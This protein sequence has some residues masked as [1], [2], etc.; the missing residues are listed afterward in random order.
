MLSE[1]FVNV[2]VCQEKSRLISIVSIARVLGE[3]TGAGLGGTGEG[4][5]E[6]SEGRKVPFTTTMHGA[7]AAR[8]PRLQI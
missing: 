7:T 2:R 8:F 3:G 5:K 1:V 6:N 4:T